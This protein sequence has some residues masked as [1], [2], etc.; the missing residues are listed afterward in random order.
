MTATTPWRDAE[1][2]ERGEVLG[3][4]RHPRVVGRDDQQGGRHRADAGEH[5]GE[6]PLV[7]R[8]VDEGDLSADRPGHDVQA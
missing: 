8:D 5:R 2:V 6:E 7:A 1:R 4:L 3:R